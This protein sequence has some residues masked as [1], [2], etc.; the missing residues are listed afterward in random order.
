MTKISKVFLKTI[1]RH[2]IISIWEYKMDLEKNCNLV[3]KC[4]WNT[5]TTLEQLGANMVKI[6]SFGAS[7]QRISCLFVIYAKGKKEIP[8]LFFEGIKAEIL[9]K[10]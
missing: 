5:T 10:N 8:T 4:G 6:H 1:W 2:K 9:E 7:K 3:D